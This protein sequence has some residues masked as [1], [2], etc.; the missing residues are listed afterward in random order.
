M[1]NHPVQPT[2]QLSEWLSHFSSALERSDFTSAM[3]LFHKAC[4]WRDLL[5]FTWNIKTAE[6]KEDIRSMLAATVAQTVPSRWQLAG[7]VT[8]NDDG[9]S[10][11]CTFE[12]AVGRG[13]G[14]VRLKEGKCWTLFTALSELSGFEEKKGAS[15][16]AG[17]EHG[18]VKKRTSWHERKLEEEAALGYT[19]QPYCVI[20][21]GGQGGIALAARFRRLDV[22]TIVIEKNERA[23]DSWRKRYKSLCLHDVIWQNHLP[24]MPF[25]DDWPVFIPK[26]KMGD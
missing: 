21:G 22:P 14:H 25:P 17:T 5:A 16:I 13:Q 18:V 24:Y 19:R 3:G 7:E 10:G 20:I 23:G 2:E 4:Y 12:T 1:N 6:G 15:R 11:W 26:D 9:I 8:V